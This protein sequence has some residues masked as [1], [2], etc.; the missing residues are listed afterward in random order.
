M[1]KFSPRLWVTYRPLF[2]NQ[3]TKKRH[4][5]DNDLNF[6]FLLPPRYIKDVGQEMTSSFIAMASHLREFN[7]N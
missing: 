5:A 3:Q 6:R 1:G 4:L 7:K 2:D